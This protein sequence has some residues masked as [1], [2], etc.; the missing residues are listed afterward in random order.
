MGIVS[1]FRLLLLSVLALPGLAQEP[2][3]ILLNGFDTTAAQGGECVVRPDSTQ[4]FGRLQEFLEADGREV[5]FFD[6]CEFGTPA[7]EELGARLGVRIAELGADQ[8]DLVG[9]S[10]GGLIIRSYLAGKGLENSVFAPLPVAKVRKAVFLAT[11]HFGVP[12][13]TLISGSTQ[14]SQMRPGSRFSWDLA[15][16]NQGLDDLR[17]ID[18]IAVVG[19]GARDGR[20]DGVV[21]V[22]SGSLLSFV[23]Q[24]PERTRVIPACHNEAAFILCGTT[25]EVTD[26]DS[27]EHPTAIAVR[28]FLAGED[29]WMQVGVPVSEHPQTSGLADAILELRAA[30]NTLIENA[31]QVVAELPGG[32]TESIN[33]GAGAG[34]F[35]EYNTAA[36]ALPT[37]ITAGDLGEIMAAIPAAAN[38]T[39]ITP[40]KVG[41]QIVRVV[42]SA[43]L[44]DGL[45]LAPDSL[46]SL[47]GQGFTDTQA[48]AEG[49]P[50]PTELA[51]V[52]V[53]LNGEA[54]GLLFAGPGQVNA[55]FPAGVTGLRTLEIESPLG[56]HS[57]NILLEAAA[58]A[59]F[60]LNGGGTGA[61]AAL[62][63]QSF[64]LIT[65]E[66]PIANGRFVALYVT[67][68]GDVEVE[69]LLAS[70]TQEVLFAGPAPGFPG[71]QQVNFQVDSDS[72]EQTL[73]VKANGRTS[74]VATLAIE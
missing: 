10:M 39:R 72:G 50:L 28:A 12:L 15:T 41:P 42:P 4:T 33:R 64:T 3:V 20:G 73:T 67:G 49:L 9:F 21:G 51:G 11:P 37:T 25:A 18:A 2:P 32:G 55:L 40:V 36:E 62:D 31:T 46:V 7:I 27:E 56:K 54:L 48:A 34:I 14:L 65:A 74:N 57:V 29:G 30:D 38:S 8:V 58:P 45:S 68:I 5:V 47:F 16:W 24:T 61:A 35:Y 71:L 13:A 63:A 22:H 69:V 17:E 6:N 1:Q 70:Q 60:T 59:I 26:V 43:G 44:V 23:G 52:R 53:S 19:S 66:T